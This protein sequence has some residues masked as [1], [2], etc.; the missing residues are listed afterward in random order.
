MTILIVGGAGFIGKRLIRYIARQNPSHTVAALDSNA[1]GLALLPDG[2][3]RYTCDIRRGTDVRRV[4]N[5]AKPDLVIHTAALHYIPY[6]N[7]H[8]LETLQTN[9]L[10][11][12]NIL[13]AANMY[14]VKKVVFTS[15][16]AV[17]ASGD[18]IAESSPKALNDIY[19]FTKYVCELLIRGTLHCDWTM[20]RLFNVYGPGDEIPHLIPEL[21]AQLRTSSQVILGNIETKRDYVFVDDVCAALLLLAERQEA[22]RSIYNVGTGRSYSAREVVQTLEGLLEKT[23]EITT[24]RRKF[25]VGD[26]PVL[27]ANSA[28][29]RHV[30]WETRHTLAEGLSVMRN[31]F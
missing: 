30:G 27:C 24:T 11:T 29:L 10:G 19:G 22:N 18:Q 13:R 25:R 6:C 14:G 26:K 20:A 15:S 31:E 2:V 23:I 16:A 7:D 17:Y 8:I 12:W 3:Q 21:F 1:D 9:V 28:R 4:F 5:A